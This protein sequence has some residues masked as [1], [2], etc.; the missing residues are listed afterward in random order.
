MAVVAQPGGILAFAFV[1]PAE[2]RQRLGSDHL[3]RLAQTGACA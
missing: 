1:E 2:L 3:T